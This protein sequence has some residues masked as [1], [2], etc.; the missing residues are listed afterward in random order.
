MPPRGIGIVLYVFTA[1]YTGANYYCYA[2]GNVGTNAVD[3]GLRTD[4]FCSILSGIYS[5]YGVTSFADS[6][7]VSASTLTEGTNGCTLTTDKVLSLGVD[8]AVESSL[9]TWIYLWDEIGAFWGNSINFNGG[10]TC[11]FGSWLIFAFWIY[12]TAAWFVSEISW[13]NWHLTPYGQYPLALNFLQS[14]VL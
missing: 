9:S 12:W 8:S 3:S 14:L 10:I 2:T 4:F 11:G 1:F 5:F 13:M 7:L 6:I